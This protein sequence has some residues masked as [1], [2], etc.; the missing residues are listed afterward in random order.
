VPG[1][2]PLPADQQLLELPVWEADV[3]RFAPLRARLA[4]EGIGFTT[5]AAEQRRCADWLERF[6]ALDNATR[7][8]TGDPAVPRTLEQMRERLAEFQLVPEACFLAVHDG[9]WVGYTLLDPAFSDGVRLAQG[10]TG[11]LPAYRRRGIAT[12]LKVMG[13]EY[14]RSCGYRSIV[15]A[16]RRRNLPSMGMSAKVGFR[17]VPG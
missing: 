10:W 12:V 4:A 6:R 9:I 16:P 8:E 2:S 5:L 17:D 15:T 7:G 3:E 14:A 1:P 11:V 13:V